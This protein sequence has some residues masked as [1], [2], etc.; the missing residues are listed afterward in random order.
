MTG[1]FSDFAYA[2]RTFVKK[3]AFALT[4]IL[5]L[6]LGIGASAAI[7]SVVNAVLLR[8]LPYERPDRLVHIAHDLRARNVEDFP[9]APAD[10][11]DLRLQ[12]TSFD[13]V[14]AL[15][16]GRQVFPV[17]GR[18]EAEQVRTGGATPNLFRLLGAKVALG[19]NF[20]EADGTP[21]PPP[22]QV[23]AGAAPA[24]APAQPPPT[25]LTILSHEF[26]QRR[27]GGD[28]NIVGKVVR[29]GEQPFE[30]VGVLEPGFELLYPPSINVEAAPDLWT[31]LRV[32][33]AAGSR[34]NV[35]LRVIGRLKDGVT[36]ERA[37]Q[38]LDALAAD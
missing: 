33:F 35:F 4:A 19:R 24:P 23:A 30:I 38:D 3:P 27:F 16:T 2:A 6:A 36:Q 32:D 7:F 28:P 29:L 15:T 21:L 1:F 12:T 34:V 5:T 10:F 17:E 26:W 20:T 14:A 37:Q 31:P 25:P 22:P 9:W 11:A 18:A 8:A 13:G